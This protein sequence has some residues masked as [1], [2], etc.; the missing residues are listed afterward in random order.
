MKKKLSCLII[1]LA[2]LA[3]M[4]GCSD[5]SAGTDTSSSAKYNMTLTLWLPTSENTTD[6][7]ITK[8][9]NA[10]NKITKKNGCPRD[11]RF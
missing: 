2:M 10:I 1:A 3:G 8:V 5:G 6:A 7:A 11:S 4:S 9:E